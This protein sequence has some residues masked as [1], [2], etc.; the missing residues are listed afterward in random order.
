MERNM[1]YSE[2][3]GEMT[4]DSEQYVLHKKGLL[5]EHCGR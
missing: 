5:T 2:Q 3:C 4:K 1:D